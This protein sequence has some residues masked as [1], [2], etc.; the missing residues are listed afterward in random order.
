MLGKSCSRE[1]LGRVVSELAIHV[2]MKDRGANPFQA[3][4]FPHFSFL[5]TA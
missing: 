5:F 3:V 2:T 4:D 1:H